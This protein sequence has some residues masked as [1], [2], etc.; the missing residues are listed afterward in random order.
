MDIGFDPARIRKV[1][2]LG[3]EGTNCET[4]A[5]HWVKL[6]DGRASI[7]LYSTLEEATKHLVDDHSSV[8][9]SCIAYPE[10]HHLVFKNLEVMQLVD[11]FVMPTLPMVLASSGSVRPRSV[12]TH[13]APE[14]LVPDWLVERMYVNSNADA[15]RACKS[16]LAESCITTLRAAELNELLVL[17]NFGEIPMGFA[18]HWC[19]S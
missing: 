10:L 17:K 18:L 16:G 11:A 12:A 7:S 8:L 9:L 1:H 13:R 2:T 14:D 19:A 3:P 4:A 5:R 6:H 15:A